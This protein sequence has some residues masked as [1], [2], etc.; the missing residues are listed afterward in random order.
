VTTRKIPA[1]RERRL[2]GALRNGVV[3][4][5]EAEYTSLPT[6][7][8]LLHPLMRSHDARLR[9]PSRIFLRDN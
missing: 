8:M 4:A 2:G 9:Q 5:S 6:R 7:W 1:V 3:L